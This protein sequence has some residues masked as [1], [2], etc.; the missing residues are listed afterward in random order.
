MPSQKLSISFKFSNFYVAFFPGYGSHF[1]T[2]T[3]CFAN[4]FQL[5]LSFVN[6]ILL[7]AGFCFFSLRCVGNFS[8]RQTGP[9]C[10]SI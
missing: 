2:S 1:P 3:V 10:G 5:M 7:S 9:F 4:N 8:W 6:V